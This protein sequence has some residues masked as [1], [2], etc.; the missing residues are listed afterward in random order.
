[1]FKGLVEK[2]RAVEVKKINHGN[3]KIHEMNSK[4]ELG[5]GKFESMAKHYRIAGRHLVKGTKDGIDGVKYYAEGVSLAPD[6]ATEVVAKKVNNYIFAFEAWRAD[7]NIRKY[8]EYKL[9]FESS[10][11]LGEMIQNGLSILEKEETVAETTASFQAMK[12]WELLCAKYGVE[13]ATNWI[14]QNPEMWEMMKG[15][16]K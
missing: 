9:L 14:R 6:A 10:A 7:G 15:G 12:A 13:G 5:N 1:M 8:K 11:M 2:M 4:F 16:E 3:E